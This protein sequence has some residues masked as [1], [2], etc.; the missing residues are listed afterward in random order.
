MS[1]AITVDLQN[2]PLS[3]GVYPSTLETFLQIL[4][5]VSVVATKG[6]C[7]HVHRKSGFP[8]WC[9]LA[10]DLLGRGRPCAE[11]N[12]R[13]PDL[14][15]R[16]KTIAQTCADNS[17]DNTD[18]VFGEFGW[19]D[20][21]STNGFAMFDEALDVAPTKAAGAK[22]K[23]KKIPDGAAVFVMKVMEHEVPIG[24]IEIEDLVDKVFPT[25]PP[26]I[27]SEGKNRTARYIR[28]AID[29]LVELE[30]L[31]LHNGTRVS[32]SALVTGEE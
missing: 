12:V 32:L 1:T 10:P 23:K 18:E 6:R 15:A 28:A 25:V 2:D 26:K 31:Y 7:I 27:D 13:G 22:R 4:D 5:P 19:Q 29:K 14:Y 9:G 17:A 16:I 3:V 30:I 20:D 24:T 8:T 21:A 11:F